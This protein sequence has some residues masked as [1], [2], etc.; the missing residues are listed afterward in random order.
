MSLGN[1]KKID[2]RLVNGTMDQLQRRISEKLKQRG[3]HSF[4]SRHEIL[5][6]ITEEYHELVD[7]IKLDTTAYR[8]FIRNELFDIA[9]TC[10]WGILSID[11]ESVDW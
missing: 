5:G 9:I 7:A 11:T 8:R 4:A 1:R 10:V 2:E 3:D 6:L